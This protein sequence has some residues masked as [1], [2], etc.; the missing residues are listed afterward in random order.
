MT[1]DTAKATGAALDPV[2]ETSE[3]SF[4]ASDPPSWTPTTSLGPP[5]AD[6]ETDRKIQAVAEALAHLGERAGPVDVVQHLRATAG[7]HLD[8]EEV[9]TIIGHLRPQPAAPDASRRKP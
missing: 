8:R 9:A 7:M 4:P 3:E 1:T 6:P 5:P 2:Q